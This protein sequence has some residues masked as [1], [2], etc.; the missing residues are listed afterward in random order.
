MLTAMASSLMSLV[1]FAV[2]ASA[3]G[4]TGRTWSGVGAGFLMVAWAALVA[5]GGFHA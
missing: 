3:P 5:G 4:V 1:C 2:G